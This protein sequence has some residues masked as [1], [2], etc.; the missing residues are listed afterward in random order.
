M[1]FLLIS[2]QAS[3]S[4]RKFLTASPSFSYSIICESSCHVFIYRQNK[5]VTS[6]EL[7]NRRSGRKVNSIAEQQLLNI[8]D[9]EI[10]GLCATDQHLYL[11]LPN[12][13]LIVQM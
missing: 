5:C 8:G 1:L 3:K 4:Q 13:I 10:L 6:G 9:E 12:K 7:R 11:L 2:L